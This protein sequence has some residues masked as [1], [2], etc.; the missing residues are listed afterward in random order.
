MVEIKK[1]RIIFIKKRN[2]IRIKKANPS[3]EKA[4]VPSAVPRFSAMTRR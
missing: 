4:K 2:T 1:I 3:C